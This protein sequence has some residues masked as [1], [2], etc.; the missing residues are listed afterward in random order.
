MGNGCSQLDVPHAL[1]ADYGA[2]NFHAAFFA[3]NILVADAAIF[4]A[5]ALVILFRSEY[6][7]VK[8]TPALASAGAIVYRF[9]LGHFSE[10][11]FL[12]LFRRR[13]AD[14]NLIKLSCV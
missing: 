2:G 13:E 5:V 3:D 9:R 7:L 8:K 14:C 4:S 6:F 1:A 10:R 12:D 11:P